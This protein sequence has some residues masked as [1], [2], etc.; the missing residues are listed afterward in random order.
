MR[1]N[2]LLVLL[3]VLGV[4]TTWAQ[5]QVSGKVV[6]AEDNAPLVGVTI[7]VKGTTTGTI[8]DLDGA[9]SIEVPA[10]ATLVFS[11]T[12]FPTKEVGVGNQSVIDVAMEAGVALDEVVVTAL[13]ISRDRK[14]LQYSVTEV[15]G[16]N[17]TQARENN[18]SNALAG[19]V[20]G[21][22]VSKIA[23]GPA[24]SSRVIIRGNKS[25]NGNNQPLYV[26][27]GIPMDNS[28]FGQAGLWG[29]SDEGD[30]MSSINPDDI[31]SI[32]VLKGANAAALYGS[33]AA[34]GV[35]NIITKKGT[36]RKGIGVEFNS[37]YVIEALND[38]SDLQREFGSG[39]NVGDLA[40]GVATK[41]ATQAQAYDWG[42]DSWGPRLDGSSVVQFDGV[43]RPYAYAGDNFDRY[44][45]SGE[46]WTNSLALTGGSET[47]SFRFSVSDLRSTTIIPNSG[48][49]RTNISFSTVSKFG[50]KLTLDAKILYSF[51]EAKNRPRLSDSPANGI[52]SV[53]RMPPNLNVNDYKGDPNKLGAIPA[54]T[55]AESLSIW[56]KS[57]GEEYQQAANNWGQNPWWVA[58][59]FTNTDKRDR[60]ITSGRLRYDITDFL[61]IQG[62]AGMDWY[63]RREQFITPQ[64]TGYQRAGSIN[65]GENRVR[66][67]NLEYILGF[68]KSFGK[69]NVN[70]FA[71]GNWMRRSNER[72]SA[73]G[74]GFSVPFFQAINNAV[75]R[76]YGYGFSES[77][78]NSLF[79]SA[80]L[81]YGGYLFLTGTIRNDWFS[82][83]NPDIN[84]ILY[85]SVGASF[86]FSD[87]FKGL[88]SWLSFG[89]V[90]A[91]WAEVGSS[92]IGPYDILLTYSLKQ[93]H[94]GR[95]LASFSS[96][97]GNGG[98]IPNFNLLPLTSREIEFGVDLRFFDN[99][100]GVDLTYYSQKSF[101]DQLRAQ[102]SRGSGFGSVL[103]NL[104]EIQNRG[105]EALINFVPVRTSQFTWDLSFNIAKNENKV[106][107]LIEGNDLLNFEE[108]RT[109][110]VF[111]SHIVGYP[112]GMLTGRVQ[113]RTPDGQPIFFP[114][115]R[116]VGSASYEIIG[117][118]IADWTGGVNNS[119]SFKNF[120]LSFLIDFKIGG[121]IFS[122]TNMRLTQW[123]LHKQSLQGRQGEEPLTVSGVVQNGTDSNGQPIYEPFSKTLTSAEAQNY[124]NSLGSEP[125][126]LTDRF[127]YDASFAKLRQLT[128]GYNF[129]RKMLEKTP[130]QN[131]S[132]SFVG[133]NLSV[134]S[135]NID[136]IDPESTYS[137]GNAQG[138]DYFGMPA[139][140]SYGFNLRAG[141]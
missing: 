116:P 129:P 56:Q 118:G 64:G 86:V 50:K 69:L 55:S 47:Q 29:G 31:E 101:N 52:Q 71:G 131:L 99:R 25:L 128:F 16:E 80:E 44:F 46:A 119:F 113:R 136:N 75:T 60:I 13:G 125:N 33:R 63:T 62:R 82:V 24:G 20:A 5:Q 114:D 92:T 139:T 30:G 77:G 89:K 26:V 70:L 1:N 27:D 11:Y 105:V 137:S 127:I 17:F 10:N 73:D 133:R 36:K 93:S 19:R 132:L 37:N 107:S 67:I 124:W 14:A 79:G 97:G 51:E 8:T 39:S 3:F 74:Q 104:G 111:V 45:Q 15:A 53:W 58:Y 90:R 100:V 83:L 84:D 112:F 48:Y 120:N 109:R 108:P 123:G 103:V 4:S 138:L 115:G 2:L 121:D 78:I 65:E 141:F 61:Y 135:K 6:N 98:N 32:T 34:N 94:V 40:T 126:G 76:N 12:G 91:S 140:R 110:N 54:N 22:N 106:L 42:D 38:Q 81:G 49:D 95:T 117:N 96:A 122:G 9:Y 72:I 41:P 68:D 21:V 28:G 18:L 88:P 7:L 66:E 35:I 87:A 130:F 59:Q 23:S 85:P 43:S 134:L 102:I 57:V